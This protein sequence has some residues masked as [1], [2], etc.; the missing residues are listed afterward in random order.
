[1]SMFMIRKNA[2]KINFNKKLY[3]MLDELMRK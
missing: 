2:V 3:I 1:M